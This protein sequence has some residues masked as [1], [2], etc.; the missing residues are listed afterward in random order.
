MLFALLASL[1]LLVPTGVVTVTTAD[2]ETVSGVLKLKRFELETDF[3][4]AT[5]DADKVERIDFGEPDLVTSLGGVELEGRLRLRSLKVQTDGGTKT[6]RRADL[7]SLVAGAAGGS[8]DGFDG[9][10]MTRYGPMTLSVKGAKVTGTYGFEDRSSIEGRVRKGRLEFEYR[11]TSSGGEGWFELW[12]DGRTFAGRYDASG[13]QKDQFWGGYRI[14]HVIAPGKPGEVTEGQTESFLNYHL[15]MP[16]DF[17]DG[18]R[19]P[20]I[21]FFHG[22]NMSSR[23]YVD[24]IA[25]TWPDLARDFV[26]VGFDGERLSS[27]SSEGDRRFNASYINFSGHEVGNPWR[28]RQTPGL[29]NDALQELE[30]ALPIDRWFV[31]GHSQG[32]FLSYAILMFYPERIAGVFPMAC[33]LLVQCEPSRFDDE[34]VRARQRAVPIAAIHGRRDDVVGF[35]GGEYCHEAFQDG[36]FPM[37]RLFDP[38]SGHSFMHLPVEDAVRWLA[39]MASDDP[40]ALVELAERSLEDDRFRDATAAASRAEDLGA[41]GDLSQRIRAVHEAVDKAAQRDADKLEQAIATN[42]NGRW[43]DDFWEFRRRFAFTPA[44]QKVMALYAKVRAEHQ[45]PADDQFYASRSKDDVERKRM[46]LEI[47]EK[48]W[49]SSWYKAIKRWWKVD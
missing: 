18:Q 12:E 34:D 2:G 1:S 41:S 31:G 48:Y 10:W 26:I 28:Y 13:G 47:N 24:T 22:S 49:G 44:A 39:G 45:K 43:V 38:E 11:G 40:Q 35:S 29:V 15:R 37:L 14:A 17:E 46:Q 20:A 42:R 16:D 30:Q 4:S 19:Y 23:P 8:T 27:T 25:S 7:V 9:R 32:G 5:I 3:G 33:N 6:I 21:A 36:G